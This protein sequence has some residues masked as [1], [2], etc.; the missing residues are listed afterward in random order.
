[1]L[2]VLRLVDEDA[3]LMPQPGLSSLPTLLDQARV[4]GLTVNLEE[5]GQSRPL[6]AG[7]D[8]TAYRIIQESLTNIRRHSGARKADVALTWGRTPLR[9]RS[10]TTGAARSMA[11]RPRHRGNAGAGCPVRRPRAHGLLAG[12]RLRRACPAAGGRLV[13]RVVV[14]DDQDLVRAG[15]S[16][17]LERNGVDVVGEA[18][19]GVEAIAV[20]QRHPPRC[21]A[22][23]HP[24]ARAWMGLRPR[25][26]SRPRF[27]AAGCWC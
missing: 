11:L 8:L 19:D 4:S 26:G 2:D 15:F 12:S 13:T 27:R 20:V 6:P 1:M 10:A 25:D 3:S 24:D 14:A 23:G 22:D 16:L 21:R 18:R 7:L 17:I 5:V 9:S